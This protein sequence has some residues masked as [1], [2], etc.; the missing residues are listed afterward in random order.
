M[1]I[2]D[3]LE[4]KN[5]VVEFTSVVCSLK[6]RKLVF[7]TNELD[8]HF[9]QKDLRVGKLKFKTIS[10]KTKIMDTLNTYLF[11]FTMFAI[12]STLGKITFM[13]LVN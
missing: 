1:T 11:I 8:M 6:E 4:K 5:T 3:S 13:V 10:N 2:I 12:F 9:L 7:G